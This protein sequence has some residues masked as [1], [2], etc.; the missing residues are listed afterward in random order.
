MT[1]QSMQTDPAEHLLQ[2]GQVQVNL[3]AAQAHAANVLG[4]RHD[5]LADE[6]LVVKTLL[7]EAFGT[8]TLRPWRVERVHQ[9]TATVLAYTQAD[10]G[11]LQCAVTAAL[12]SVQGALRVAGVAAQPI[13]AGELR[14]FAVR[15][16]PVINVTPG[17]QRRHGERD[18]F[19][20]ALD[21]A[22]AEP[23]DRLAV[24][25]EYLGA[26]LPGAELLSVEA[27]QN[28]RLRRSYRPRRDRSLAA[29]TIPDIRLH[30]RLRIADPL[31]FAETL[32]AG[33]G[34]HRAYGFGMVRLGAPE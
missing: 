24:Y 9:A 11:T 18:A 8:R 16:C 32:H 33:V 30:G 10:Q 4:W 23:L 26:R 15:L 12:P 17:P 21:R 5:V 6:G 22:P 25:A 28:V 14:P 7:T 27:A 29:K 2:L 13:A 3:P 1:D 31:A 34:G 20:A 19:L